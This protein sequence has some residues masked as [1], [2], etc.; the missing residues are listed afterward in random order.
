MKLAN[1]IVACVIL[2][3]VLANAVAAQDAATAPNA[4]GAATGNLARPSK[5]DPPP[6]P[7]KANPAKSDDD[8][9]R[10]GVSCQRDT[11]FKGED[12]QMHLCK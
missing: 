4:T 1:L 7:R 5:G 8:T 3:G 9:G 12:G 11:F 10:K 2:S 6:D